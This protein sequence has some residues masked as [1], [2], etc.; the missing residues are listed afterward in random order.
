M[1]VIAHSQQCSGHGAGTRPGK[2]FDIL[3]SSYLLQ[4]LSENKSLNEPRHDKTNTFA[5]IMDPDQP[6]LPRI[7]IKIHAV[8][9]QFLYLL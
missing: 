3:V 1:R 2:T 7:L 8:R 9:Y 5:T 4:N 6:A